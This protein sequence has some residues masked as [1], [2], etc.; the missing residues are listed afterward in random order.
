M[1]ETNPCFSVCNLAGLG[2]GGSGTVDSASVQA[3]AKYVPNELIVKFKPGTRGAA[4]ASL[5][6][7]ED[8][9]VIS[10]N[11]DIGF[12]VIKLKDQSVQQALKAYKANPNIDMPNP[13][14]SSRLPG[15][16]MT[17]TIP[18]SSTDRR[19]QKPLRPGMSPEAV[20]CP[21]RHCGHGS[22]V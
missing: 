9:E 18:P 3:E 1:C 8:A 6:A 15:P 7:Q 16:L 21:N 22:A 20:P 12:E 2:H 13:T 11:T 19:S 17:P 5:H 14:L 4:K 10:R